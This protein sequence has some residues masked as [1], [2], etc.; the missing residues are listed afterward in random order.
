MSTTTTDPKLDYFKQKARRKSMRKWMTIFVIVL[1]AGGGA[2]YYFTKADEAPQIAI[3]YATI[4][5]GD[6]IKSISATG[7][8]QATKTVQVG[9]QVSGTVKALFA[10]FNSKVKKGDLVAVIDP[11]FYEAAVKQSQANFEKALADKNKTKR[12]NDRAEELFKKDLISKAEHDAAVAAYETSTA[13]VKQAEASLEQSKVNLSYTQIRA[14][15]SGT[16]IA[17]SV[18]V[19]QTVA[20]SLNA[21][22]IFIIAED[23]Q[24]M[25]VWASVGEADIGSVLKGQEVSFTVD[26]FGDEKFVGTV[27]SV[28]LNATIVQNVV[29][30]TVIIDAD[31]ENLK[32]L[33]SMTATVTI[34]NTSKKDVLRLPV[35][36]LRFTPPMMD[37][38]KPTGTVGGGSRGSHQMSDANDSASGLT[39]GKVYLKVANQYASKNFGL[40]AVPVMTGISDGLFIE[41][42]SSTKNIKAGDSVAVG[43]ITLSTPGATTAAPGAS[44][45]GTTNN[46]AGQGMRRP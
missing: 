36:A 17:R 40:E 20:A 6:I 27:N 8:I 34:I 14:P 46:R 9:S 18:D 13:S 28:R 10:D 39:K 15:I 2:Y 1:L 30:Y 44:P 43:S 5:R 29:N 7:T 24:K 11:T 33:P 32:L 21:P 31:N 22:V 3:R 4:E 19:G 35:A 42:A 45:F 12:D 37:K 25:Q 26:A 41:L 16:V 23:L 38:P